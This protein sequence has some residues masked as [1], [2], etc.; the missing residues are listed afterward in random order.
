MALSRQLSEFALALEAIGTA[1]SAVA[2]GIAFVRLRER[3]VEEGVYE[4]V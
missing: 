2:L 3:R 4:P 1:M